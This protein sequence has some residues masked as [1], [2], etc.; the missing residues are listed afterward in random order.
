MSELELVSTD[1]LIDE[2]LNRHDHG[3]ICLRKDD[4]KPDID[5][6]IRRSKG[7]YHTVIGIMFDTAQCMVEK[8]RENDCDEHGNKGD[9]E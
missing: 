9:P 5:L 1:D 3:A 7:D 4:A 8:L 2:L 6:I